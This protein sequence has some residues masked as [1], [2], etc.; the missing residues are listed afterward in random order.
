MTLFVASTMVLI[1]YLFLGV[2]LAIN[3]L[4]RGPL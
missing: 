4:P 2:Q 3:G 1:L